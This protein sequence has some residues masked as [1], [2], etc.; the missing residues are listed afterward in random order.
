VAWLPTAAPRTRD[1]QVDLVALD[2]HDAADGR[3]VWPLHDEALGPRAP[4]EPPADGPADAVE[5]TRLWA[6]RAMAAL[7]SAGLAW[8]LLRGSGLVASLAAATPLWRQLDPIPI[9]GGDDGTTQ[10]ALDTETPPPDDEEAARDEAASAEL[11]DD[12]RRRGETLLPETLL[13]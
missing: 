1:V 10:W 6:A 5:N 4:V 7:L 11:L 13:P 8:W 2:E 12:A 3:P 9:L